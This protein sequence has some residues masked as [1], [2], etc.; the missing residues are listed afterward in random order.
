MKELYY[1]TVYYI[2]LTYN[3]VYYAV[4]QFLKVLPS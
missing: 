1:A 3:A 4:V 2:L